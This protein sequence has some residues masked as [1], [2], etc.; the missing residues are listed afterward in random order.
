MAIQTILAMTAE[1]IRNAPSAFPGGCIFGC[2]FSATSQDLVGLPSS[3]PQGWGLILDDRNPI[4][5]PDLPGLLQQL[6]RP[7]PAYIILD[8]QRPATPNALGLAKEI[9]ALPCP[10]AMP[11]AYGEHLRCPLFLPPIPPHISAEEYL[12]PWLHRDIWLELALDAVE[13]SVT[14]EGSQVKSFPHV[15]VTDNAHVDSMLH[16]HYKI[17]HLHD[18]L[19]FYCYRTEDDVRQLLQSP[20]PANVKYGV[21]F[22]Q[23]LHTII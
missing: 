1:E 4:I 9:A 23:E 12:Q 5:Q 19:Q 16:C 17:S 2:H 15:A 8:F 13:L 18:A 7:E 10:A 20:L 6:S 22:F 3:L 21:G 11:P 14:A